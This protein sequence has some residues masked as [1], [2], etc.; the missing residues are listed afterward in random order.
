MID[1]NF[2]YRWYSNKIKELRS[3][4]EVLSE[5]NKK[6]KNEVM[7]LTVKNINLEQEILSES[8]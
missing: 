7:D 5:E 1:E 4:N 2:G 3:Q 8:Y 6:L